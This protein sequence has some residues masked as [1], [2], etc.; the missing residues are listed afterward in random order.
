MKKIFTE[1]YL[2]DDSYIKLEFLSQLGKNCL[3]VFNKFRYVT[4]DLTSCH[5]NFEN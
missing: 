2:W 5:V 3:N 4:L 1:S